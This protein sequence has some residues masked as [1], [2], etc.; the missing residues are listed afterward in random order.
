[1]LSWRLRGESG[2]HAPPN[3]QC[4][5]TLA[6]VNRGF[7]HAS[8]SEVRLQFSMCKRCRAR[9]AVPQ[10]RVLITNSLH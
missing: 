4:N 6:A 9:L 5:V 1:M 10:L 8:S 2:H 3:Q 7:Q